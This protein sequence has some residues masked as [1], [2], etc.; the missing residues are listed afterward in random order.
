M[1]SRWC[2]AADPSTRFAVEIMIS[3]LINVHIIIRE[4]PKAAKTVQIP[5]WISP[6]RFRVIGEN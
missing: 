6:L 3:Q 2:R 1:I 5:D 4:D